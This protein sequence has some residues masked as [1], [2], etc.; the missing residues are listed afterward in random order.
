MPVSRM[1][2]IKDKIINVP[3]PLERIKKNVECLPRTFEEASVI[4]I[5]IKRKKEYISYVFHHYVRPAIIK[6][7]IHFLAD[8]YPFN[9]P[10]SFDL[11]KIDDLEKI[12]IDDMEEDLEE[13][14]P[15]YQLHD[16]LLVDNTEADAEY[17]DIAEKEYQEKDAV[18]KHQTPVSE[19]YF[20]LPENLPGE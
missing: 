16:E 19:S 17:D 12:C 14:I 4:P 5:M 1:S 2:G 11:K 6:K 3:I 20:L 18:K 7:A 9:E 13:I 10:I 15:S 8:K